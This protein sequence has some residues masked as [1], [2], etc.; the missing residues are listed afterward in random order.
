MKKATLKVG[1]TPQPQEKDFLR[2]PATPLS[3]DDRTAL[4][5]MFA[6]PAFKRAWHN[7]QLSQ[8]SCMP[9]VGALDDPSRGPHIANNQMHRQQG[10][11]MFKAALLRQCDDPMPPKVA[12][13][14]K[15][16]DAGTEIVDPL[17]VAPPRLAFPV[18]PPKK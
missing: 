6:S 10:W 4:R 3:F 15:Y 8:P 18:P 9:G 14:D 7:A 16:S 5:T 2:I 12:A 11:E 17:K 1:V 13:E